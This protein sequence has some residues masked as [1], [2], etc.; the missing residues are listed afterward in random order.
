MNS[1]SRDLIGLVV[2]W[3]RSFLSARLKINLESFKVNRGFWE[4]LTEGWIK[5]NTDGP[6]LNHLSR[7]TVGGVFRGSNGGWVSGFSMKVGGSDMRDISLRGRESRVP[8]LRLI[9]SLCRRNWRVV[10]KHSSSE[11]NRGVD[12]LA[13]AAKG[14][15]SYSQLQIFEFPPYYI[16]RRIGIN[17]KELVRDKASRTLYRSNPPKQNLKTF[18]SLLMIVDGSSPLPLKRRRFTSIDSMEAESAKAKLAAAKEKFGREIRVFETASLLPTQDGVP[19]TEEPDD[20]YDFTAED[21]YRLM[22]SKKEDKH[23]KTRKIREAEEAAR[24]SRITKAVVRIRFPDNHTLELTFHPSETLQSLVDLISKLIARPDLPFYL[25]TTPPK[26]Q[27]KDMTQD[28]FSAGFIPGA[29]VYFSYDLPKGEDAAAANSGPFLQE[30]I[31]SLKGLEV[32][33][34]AEQPESLQSAPEP[35]SASAVPSPAVHESKPTEKKP[36][37]PKWFKIDSES[38]ILQVSFGT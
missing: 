4:S 8:E 24:R 16:R 33:A 20:F 38:F 19:N 35:A 9:H 14:S 12:G 13:K 27:I 10:F 5:L 11:Y 2:A 29:I 31:M 28:F 7:A 30:E 32:I 36:A 18:I 26:K 3:A 25:Y 17:Q 15:L 23:L 21:Y 37:K 6:F 22:A 34:G 1:N